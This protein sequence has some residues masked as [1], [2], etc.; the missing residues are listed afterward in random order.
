MRCPAPPEATRGDQQA[1][2]RALASD[3]A[4]E[5]MAERAL[6]V[7]LRRGGDRGRPR[8]SELEDPCAKVPA[9]A[10]G[11]VEDVADGSTVPLIR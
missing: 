5:V 7:P 2:R 8:R 4:E 10:H 6:P 3:G 9:V 11:H 1:L